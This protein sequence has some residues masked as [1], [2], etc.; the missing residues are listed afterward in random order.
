MK[1][2]YELNVYQ[3]AENLADKV[4]YNFDEWLVKVQNTIG[5]QIIRSVDSISANIAEGFG[6]LYA[7]GEKTFLQICKGLLRR[8]KV[9][10]TKINSP[11][12][13]LE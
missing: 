12:F 5:Y 9:L 8:N 13:N 3:L 2:V 10:V 7:E 11:K 1:E 4:W 6:P